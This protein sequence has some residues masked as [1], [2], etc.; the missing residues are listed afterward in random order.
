MLEDKDPTLTK[1]PTEVVKKLRKTTIAIAQITVTP[2]VFP[3]VIALVIGFI[4]TYLFYSQGEA[5]A[6]A[7]LILGFGLA[8]LWRLR[9]QYWWNAFGRWIYLCLFALFLIERAPAHP[10]FI[11]GQWLEVRLSPGL[12][13]CAISLSLIGLSAWVIDPRRLVKK[14][15]KRV[16]KH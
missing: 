1:A 7:P 4:A 6:H 5:D 8:I 14:Q 10:V 11:Q 13:L 9:T 15:K 12:Y 3:S 16:K 2:S